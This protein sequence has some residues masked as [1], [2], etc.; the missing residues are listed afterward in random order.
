MSSNFPKIITEFRYLAIED[1]EPLEL[2]PN[3][4]A[5]E[6]LVFQLKFLPEG[7]AFTLN[8]SGRSASTDRINAIVFNE[9]VNLLTIELSS[10][11]NQNGGV[12]E[13]HQFRFQPSANFRE[14]EVSILKNN[15]KVGRRLKHKV[16]Y[17]N[18]D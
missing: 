8:I 10:N 15:A 17:S 14:V 5:D 9:D 1:S 3:P 7:T 4:D 11:P 18:T 12:F 13:D 6:K 2:A 16:I